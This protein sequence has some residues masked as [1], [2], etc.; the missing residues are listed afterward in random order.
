MVNEWTFVEKMSEPHYGHAG[1]LPYD[2]K[3]SPHFKYLC[4]KMLF[5]PFL[6]VIYFLIIDKK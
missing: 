5:V 4:Q 1:T 2:N 3:D 6:Q